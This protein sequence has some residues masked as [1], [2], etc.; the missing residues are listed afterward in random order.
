[1]ADTPAKSA[2]APSTIEIKPTTT[3]EDMLAA[4]K[5]QGISDLQT[6]VDKLIALKKA[7]EEQGDDD[8]P[9]EAQFLIHAHFFLTHGGPI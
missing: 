3:V 8:A 4:L 1:M 7:E 2:P 6:F 9:T 5:R